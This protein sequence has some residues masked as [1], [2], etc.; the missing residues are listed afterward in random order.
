MSTENIKKIIKK[1]SRKLSSFKNQHELYKYCLKLK[2]NIK[3]ILPNKKE[4]IN[5]SRNILEI[6]NLFKKAK[7]FI[8]K[9][10][11]VSLAILSLNCVIQNF[12]N[13]KKIDQ[14]K[15]AKNNVVGKTNEE[16]KEVEEEEDKEEDESEENENE[17]ETRK[18]EE[19]EKKLG[20]NEEE[21][22][23]NK[24][25]TRK[26]EENEKK[27]EE[28]KEEI[29]KEHKVAIKNNIKN[30]EK[31]SK[32]RFLSGI[33]V[34][35]SGAVMITAMQRFFPK[36][37]ESITSKTKSSKSDINATDEKPFS[38]LPLQR[39]H[40]KP[41]SFPLSQSPHEK[42]F[43]L[44]FQTPNFSTEVEITNQLLSLFQTP[45]F[46]ID[47]ETTNQ[48]LSL[49][50]TQIFLVETEVI[51]QLNQIV[52][53]MCSSILN[54]LFYDEQYL[55]IKL[56]QLQGI[57]L[58]NLPE[59]QIVKSFMI[60]L[61]FL[62]AH[63][64]FFDISFIDFFIRNI[65]GHGINYIVKEIKNMFSEIFTDL[66]TK[67][68]KKILEILPKTVIK[69]LFSNQQIEIKITSEKYPNILKK[70]S[71]ISMNPM[72]IKTQLDNNKLK[73][74]FNILSENQKVELP[75]ILFSEK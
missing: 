22:K 69:N 36:S 64:I 20:E 2:N 19:N 15:I 4:I 6:Q 8:S 18:N 52:E 63:I 16:N 61:N 45:N 35:I 10:L 33:T 56:D 62:E 73:D 51:N 5:K 57:L 58:E 72:R 65:S 37:K 60:N 74:L 9:A 27:I 50:Q 26:N 71:E 68:P 29:G 40:Q 23:E 67:T 1:Y 54:F 53:V 42:S 47:V 41:S 39:F 43:F 66:L 24:E 17:E 21:T 48:L 44:L 46:S 49:F 34:A 28:N 12:V 7:K 32:I 11:A 25:E 31:K 14:K 13:A 38:I 59:N 3:L 30:N 75:E 70:L 55:A